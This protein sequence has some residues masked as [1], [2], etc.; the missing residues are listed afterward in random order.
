MPIPRHVRTLVDS[1][2]EL[3]RR[4]RNLEVCSTTHADPATF[5][6][7]LALVFSPDG[8]Y[9]ASSGTDRVIRLWDRAADDVRSLRGHNGNVV[10]LAFSADS[11]FLASGSTDRSVRVWDLR[12][13]QIPDR[14]VLGAL[15]DRTTTVDIG[16]DHR[17]LTQRSAGDDRSG[18]ICSDR[19][20]LALN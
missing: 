6:L 3:L 4:K 20:P 15:L 1:L 17:A 12:G 5:A 16:S 9:L 7:P 2:R 18:P 13:D 11:A 10:A 19:G 14:D 8:R